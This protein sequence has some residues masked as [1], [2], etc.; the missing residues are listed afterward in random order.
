[1]RESRRACP[2]VT[3]S[4][5]VLTTKPTVALPPCSNLALSTKVH[6]P[7]FMIAMGRISMPLWHREGESGGGEGERERER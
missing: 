2:S 1:M 7:R 3:L 4:P 6:T 5:S